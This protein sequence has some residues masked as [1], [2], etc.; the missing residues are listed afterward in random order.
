MAETGIG[1]AAV[2][3][4]TVG[5]KSPFFRL[6]R[7]ALLQALRVSEAGRAAAKRDICASR[8]GLAWLRTASLRGGNC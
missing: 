1:Y 8:L 2:S 5:S 6:G 3:M 7:R 4:E